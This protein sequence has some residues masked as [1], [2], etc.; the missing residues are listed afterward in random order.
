[1]VPRRHSDLRGYIRHPESLFSFLQWKSSKGEATDKERKQEE[2]I[3]EDDL[4]RWWVGEDAGS[5]R[6]HIHT[7]TDLH[8]H[9][10]AYMTSHY[11]ASPGEDRR[12]ARGSYRRK[13]PAL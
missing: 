13:E 10:R 1:M 5:E 4:Q 9:T 7:W 8:T 6:T 12:V 2:G 11:L 3:Q